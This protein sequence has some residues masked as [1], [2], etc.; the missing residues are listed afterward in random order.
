MQDTQVQKETQATNDMKENPSPRG[1]S[2]AFLRFV[3]THIGDT[4]AYSLLSMGLVVCF[5]DVFLGGLF[6][7]LITGL[8]FARKI[9]SSFSHFQELLLREGI[10][11]GFVIVVALG[12]LVISAPG[13][14]L[15]IIL[16]AAIRPLLKGA[17]SDDLHVE[18]GQKKKK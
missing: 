13:L 9:V 16:G 8:Y 4:I 10:F 2:N 3:K 15:G 5:F 18:E 14:V 11:R 1:K 7:G 17:L 6:V 12:A